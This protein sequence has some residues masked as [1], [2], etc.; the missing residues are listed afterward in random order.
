MAAL[1]A[2]ARCAKSADKMEGANSIKTHYSR[3]VSELILA[4]AKNCFGWLQTSQVVRL[5]D[6]NPM[7]TTIDHPAF[8]IG[9]ACALSKYFTNMTSFCAS[10]YRSSSAPALV[11][12]I[13][14]PPG[15]IPRS[16]R[17]DIWAVGSD[18][19]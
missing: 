9:T 8:L 1:A 7:K 19:G 5:R 16:S 2:S 4:C 6:H 12:R 18:S 3:F 11:I 17:T 15:R 13:P 14:K 10:L